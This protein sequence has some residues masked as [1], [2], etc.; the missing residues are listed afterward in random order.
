MWEG[1]ENENDDDDNDEYYNVDEAT[2]GRG[3]IGE[4]LTLLRTLAGKVIVP[5]GGQ[6]KRG[7]HHD[8]DGPGVCYSAMS[9]EHPER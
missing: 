8:P 4:A 2:E 7:Q 9:I 1:D 3:M 6:R 5:G